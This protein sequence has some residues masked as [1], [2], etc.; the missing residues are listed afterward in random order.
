MNN[1]KYTLLYP[2][3]YICISRK[4]EIIDLKTVIWKGFVGRISTDSEEEDIN[5]FW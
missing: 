4:I 3:M 1:V 5:P 2:I